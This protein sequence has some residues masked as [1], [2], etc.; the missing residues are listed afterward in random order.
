MY[1]S[2]H[3]VYGRFQDFTCKTSFSNVTLLGES[4]LKAIETSE[5]KKKV[6]KGILTVREVR[7]ISSVG[8]V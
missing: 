4:I 5:F 2:I 6:E 3:V 1:T 7:N 8:E